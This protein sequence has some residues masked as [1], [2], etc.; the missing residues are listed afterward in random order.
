MAPKKHANLGASKAERW[1]NCPGSVALEADL[2]NTSSE[3][4][5]EG[6]AAHEVAEQCLLSGKD[7]IDFLDEIITVTETEIIWGKETQVPYEIEVTEEMC[8]AVQMFVSYVREV[9]RGG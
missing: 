5:R 1:M 7:A 3:Y 2:P 4:A 9:A 8:E 6:T